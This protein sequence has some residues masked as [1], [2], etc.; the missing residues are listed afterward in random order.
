MQGAETVCDYDDGFFMGVGGVDGLQNAE[1]G[2]VVLLQQEGDLAAGDLNHM[3][4]CGVAACAFG[5]ELLCAKSGFEG[6]AV[7]I[8]IGQRG[9]LQHG[10]HDVLGM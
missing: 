1:G 8:A 10:V 4:S 6:D 9:F 3:F 5:P 2:G 7:V